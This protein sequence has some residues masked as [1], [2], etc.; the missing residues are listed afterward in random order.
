MKNRE[1][2]N[3]SILKIQTNEIHTRNYRLFFLYHYLAANLS[4]QINNCI[5]NKTL[6]VKKGTT[7]KLSNKYGDINCMTGKDDSLSICATVTIMQD[8]ETLLSKNMKLINIS[9]EKL[10]DTIRISTQYDKKF[11]SETARAGR[12]SFSVDYLIKMPA[13]IDLKIGNEFG[14]ISLDEV[15]GNVN[16]RLSQGQL[17]AK[18]ADKRKCKSCQYNLC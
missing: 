1:N 10:N 12:K 16:I 17:R 4:A 7:L 9:F 3:V 6:P 18:T 5:F 15:S 13:Y 8:D 14:N 11:F 2:Q